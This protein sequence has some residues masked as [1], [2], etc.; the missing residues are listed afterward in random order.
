MAKRKTSVA[1]DPAAAMAEMP[2]LAL[3]INA[4]NEQTAA[5]FGN[6]VSLAWGSVTSRGVV[7]V[8]QFAAPKRMLVVTSTGALGRVASMFPSGWIGYNI[9]NWDNT[10]E[11]ERADPAWACDIGHVAVGTARRKFAVLPSYPYSLAHWSEMVPHC[12]LYAPQCKGLQALGDVAPYVAHLTAIRGGLPSGVQLWGEVA[13]AP[14]GVAVTAKQ[15]LA[16]VRP[17]LSLVDGLWVY[18]FPAQYGTVRE[19]MQALSA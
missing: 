19:F 7:A 12:E 11:A 5:W 16:W 13:A 9:E 2:V 14:K 18:A 17:W 4:V 8:G 10:P 6:S 1:A 15:M 3:G